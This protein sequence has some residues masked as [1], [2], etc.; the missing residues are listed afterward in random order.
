M[1]GCTLKPISTGPLLIFGVVLFAQT[2]DNARQTYRLKELLGW[3]VTMPE[4]DKFKDYA[5]YAEYC[6]NTVA[7]T[8]DQESRRVHREMAAESLRLADAIRP[9][10]KCWKVH[11]LKSRQMQ[12]G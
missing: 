8:T 6:L 4:N 1:C 7:S 9:S 3:G 5:R 12:M 10:L 11:P 2:R